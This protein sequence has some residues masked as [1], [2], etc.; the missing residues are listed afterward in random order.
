MEVRLILPPPPTAEQIALAQNL[1]SALQSRLGNDELASWQFNLG[2]D[3]DRP[4]QLFRNPNERANAAQIV[5][6]F[7]EN[8][9]DGV[10]AEVKAAL[11]NLAANFEKGKR[12]MEI[13][14][15]I[16]RLLAVIL[17]GK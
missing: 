3:L 11:K 7:A 2:L 5:R 12:T 8:A 16:G 17:K 15:E 9:P 14:D 13:D 10:S 1:I 4:L 6:Q